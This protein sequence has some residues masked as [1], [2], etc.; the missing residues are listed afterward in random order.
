MPAR[1]LRVL[2]QMKM[3]TWDRII[4][5]ITLLQDAE[6]PGMHSFAPRGNEKS[7][8]LFREWSGADFPKQLTG[9]YYGF[10]TELGHSQKI[11]N[12]SLLFFQKIG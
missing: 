9:I 7:Y 11:R 2:Q 12:K 3:R 5:S 4:G 6:R 1:T 8:Q 10:L